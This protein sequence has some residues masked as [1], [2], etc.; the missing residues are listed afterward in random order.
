MGSFGTCYEKKRDEILVWKKRD[1]ERERVE[2]PY[3]LAET[4][5]E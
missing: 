3:S 4:R 5:D 1:E 2:R